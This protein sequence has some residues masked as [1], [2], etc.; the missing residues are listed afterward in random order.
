MLLKCISYP[1]MY[2]ESD[3]SATGITKTIIDESFET[4]CVCVCGGGGG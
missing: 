4:T 1:R 3:A 2:S